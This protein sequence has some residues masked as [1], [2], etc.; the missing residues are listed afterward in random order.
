MNIKEQFEDEVENLKE[1]HTNQIKKLKKENKRLKK[2]LELKPPEKPLPVPVAQ[3]N[4]KG[5]QTLP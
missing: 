4:H 5:K 3:N 2:Q 1:E